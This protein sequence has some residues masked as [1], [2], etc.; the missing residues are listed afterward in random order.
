MV[1]RRKQISE[2]LTR[3]ELWVQEGSGLLQAMRMTFS[4]GDTKLMEFENVTP[5]A[6]IDPSVFAA[7]K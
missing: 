7:P 2:T 5:N 1:P 4:N 3:L 6:A